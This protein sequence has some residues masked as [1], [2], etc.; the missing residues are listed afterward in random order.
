MLSTASPRLFY[1]NALFDL[2][3]GG[4]PVDGARAAAREMTVLFAP[5]GTGRDH[6]LLDVG[7]PQAWQRYLSGYGIDAAQPLGAGDSGEEFSAVPWGWNETSAARLAGLAA[8]SRHPDFLIVKAANSRR[9]C[10]A[11]NHATGTGVPGSRF[12]TTALEAQQAAAGLSGAFP[13]VA[14]PNFGGAGFGFVKI[15]SSEDLRAPCRRGI[16][17]LLNS[18]GFTL[19]PWCDRVYDV[20]SSCIIAEDGAIGDLRH[21]RCHTTSHGAFYAVS[22]GG[23]DPCIERRRD[24][25]EH[26][27]RQA[28]QALARAG[29]FGPAG[30]DSF[31]YREKITGEERLAPV[32]EINARFVMSAI[33]HALHAKIGEGRQ[34]LFRLLTRRRCALPDS[35]EALETL[36]GSDRYDPAKRRGIL[37]ATPLRVCHATEWV[38]PARSAFFLVAH[39]EDEAAL[40]D[41]RLRDAVGLNQAA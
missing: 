10:A 7:V 14:K 11:F 18:G 24:E 8:R 34:C 6:V 31:V 13:L 1:F 4:Y 25:L 33:A 41:K 30:F 17:R 16:T 2:E 23:A 12:C 29:Y 3:L 20:S 21:Y 9:W 22:V 36:L 38:Q 19:E 40:M 32:I 27:A 28:A 26:A 5:L 37:L 35:Y 39:S 15:D